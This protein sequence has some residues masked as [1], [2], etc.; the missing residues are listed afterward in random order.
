[1]EQIDWA[2]LSMPSMPSMQ[3]FMQVLEHDS[4]SKPVDRTKSMDELVHEHEI[5][6]NVHTCHVQI[7]FAQRH[8]FLLSVSCFVGD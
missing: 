1:M 8:S 5:V 6:F 7:R 3:V 4:L 2:A